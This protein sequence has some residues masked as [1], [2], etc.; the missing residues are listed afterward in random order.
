[1]AN[2][3]LS[4]GLEEV[5]PQ[6]E[7]TGPSLSLEEVAPPR[8]KSKPAV[9]LTSDSDM[10][11]TQKT[12]AGAG[13]ELMQYGRGAQLALRRLG[14]LVGVP[15]DP[16]E[17]ARITEEAKEEKAAS[18]ALSRE[19]LAAKLG[20]FIPGLAAP[21]LRTA[22]GAAI[23]WGGLEALKD[24]G[25]LSERA[26]SGASG[27][28]GGALGHKLGTMA[29][30]G[31]GAL[32]GK[33]ENKDVKSTVDFAKKEGVNLTAGDLG[34]RVLRTAE[35]IAQESPISGRSAALERQAKQLDD[36]LFPQGENK[37]VSGIKKVDDA[38][39]Q[40]NKELWEPVYKES[41]KSGVKVIPKNLQTQL[42]DT[43]DKY[44]DLLNKIPNVQT[45]AKLDNLISSPK[46]LTPKLS[47]ED[48]RELQQALGFLTKDFDR[49]VTM[50]NLPKDYSNSLKKIYGSIHRD[51][52]NWGANPA[53]AKAYD[54]YREANNLY[55]SAHLPW[56]ENDF[57]QKAKKGVYE[58][59]KETF[60][61][62]VLSPKNRQA[63]EKLTSYLEMTPSGKTVTEGERAAK[64]LKTTKL[65]DRAAKLLYQTGR[66]PG[67]E[68]LHSIGATGVH[69]FT[70][71]LS[72]I[73]ASP[74]MRRA[75]MAPGDLPLFQRFAAP[76]ATESNDVFSQY[77]RGSSE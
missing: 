22:K 13:G 7:Y 59:N 24:P 62:D 48:T 26:L 14:A 29:S 30:K 56:L 58:E 73:S 76:V 63:L 69:A 43:V 25:D 21:A 54:A 71:P 3:E 49:Q 75:Q 74:L 16:A 20:T 11:T 36:M 50:G 52:D 51:I 5:T 60:L 70:G 31:V 53:A 15:V 61:S 67:K 40:A 66:E 68:L 65:S 44:P 37:I 2:N 33:A 35:N 8:L 39:T 57:V 38:M 47:F 18:D 41:A 27:A 42:R 9:A 19:S 55:K 4:L 34:N 6:E 32:L 72:A 45:R 77:L 64:M 17:T 12:L 46:G 23:L 10:T 1:M 28:F